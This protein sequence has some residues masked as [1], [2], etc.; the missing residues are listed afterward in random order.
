MKKFLA[1]FIIL[2]SILIMP[3]FVFAINESGGNTNEIDKLNQQ[4]AEKQNK[5]KE[6]EKSIEDYKNKISQKRS[7]AV[8]LKNQ[9]AIIDNRVT[10]LALDVEATEQKISALELE[11]EALQLSIQD[12]EASLLKQK[13]ILA[14]LIRS[15]YY[16]GDKN[17]L[18]IITTYDNFSDFYNQFQ[19]L[20]TVQDSLGQSVRGLKIAK[21]ELDLK[22][23]K[24][25]EQ[26][27]TY[28]KTQEE[29]EQKKQNWEEQGNLKSSLLA[30]VQ[31][32]EMKYNTLLSNLRSQYQ[33][34]EGEISGIEKEV[35]KKLEAQKK[36]DDTGETETIFSWPVQSHYVTSQFHDPDYPYRNIFEHTG[37]D[38]R[39]SQGTPIKAAA[40]G[41]VAVA[42]VCT[43]ASCY[44]YVMLI[45]SDGLATVYG[46]LSKI[47]VKTDQFVT[48]G[49]IIAYSGGTRG[50]VGAGP[51]V[52]GPHLHFEVRANGIPVNPLN[53]L[54]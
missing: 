12:K 29:L 39:A 25:T 9:M 53:Y 49:D 33:Q 4:I 43:V 14:G 18:E 16:Q 44:S 1:I 48:R 45:H 38:I 6:L 54:P 20:R 27:L 11:I 42:K 35:R 19:Y 10:Q 32:S 36:I 13:K 15:I 37:A 2:I 24:V 31:T 3:I 51:F 7:E 28:Q 21:E 17:Y 47:V 22:K 23:I 34:I 30:Q 50:T 26:K 5:I 41:Y 52:T 40:S 8:S 46:H